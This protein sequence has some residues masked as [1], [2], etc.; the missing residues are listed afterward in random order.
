[1]GHS[2]LG[3]IVAHAG[4]GLSLTGHDRSRITLSPMASVNAPKGSD[5]VWALFRSTPTDAPGLL[6]AVTYVQRL[7]TIGGAPPPRTTGGARI[8]VP[9]EAAYVFYVADSDGGGRIK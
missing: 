8:E 9:Y 7:S 6:S 3:E 5:A 2:G 1:M 4:D